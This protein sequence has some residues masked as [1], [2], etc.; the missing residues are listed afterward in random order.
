MLIFWSAQEPHITYA[1]CHMPYANCNMPYANCSVPINPHWSPTPFGRPPPLTPR[2]RAYAHS[3]IRA[4]YHYRP[5]NPH[6]PSHAH[7]HAHAH[8]RARSRARLWVSTAARDRA[9]SKPP[10]ER[11]STG[12]WCSHVF[13]QK[14]GWHRPP[15]NVENWHVNPIFHY[16][17]SSQA[18]ATFIASI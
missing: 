2:R 12:A 17:Y 8:T 1:I 6:D 18:P 16:T 14:P 13:L 11:S 3:G 5:P 15:H 10:N 7:T 9:Q 4:Y